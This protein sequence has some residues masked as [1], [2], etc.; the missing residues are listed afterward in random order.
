MGNQFSVIDNKPLYAPCQE[1]R[2]NCGVWMDGWMD[3]NDFR[4]HVF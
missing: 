3:M 1:E 2:E 4:F